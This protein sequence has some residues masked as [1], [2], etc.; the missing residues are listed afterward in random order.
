MKTRDQEYARGDWIVH[1]Y[2]G[3]G[4]IVGVEKKCLEGETVSYYKVKTQNSTFWIPVKRA[5]NVRI[6]P[7]ANQQEI[8]E[9]LNTLKRKPRKMSDDHNK[10]KSR[11][12]H[13]K[14]DGT[15]VVIARIVRDLTARQAQTK[16]N[17]SE[18]RALHQFIERLITEWAA[19]M[20][21]KMEEARRKLYGILEK[22]HTSD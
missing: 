1:L 21:I 2:H 14:E 11:I 17:D 18:E 13:V 5:D 19:C 20:G 9:V 6:R 10:R 3:V 16:L 22:I 8:R 15:L 12:N 7:I 4:Q